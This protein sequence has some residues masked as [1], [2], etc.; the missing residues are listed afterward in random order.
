MR[1]VRSL[2][3][4]VVVALGLGAYIYFVES[5]REPSDVETKS[6]AFTVEADAID[7]LDITVPADSSSTTLK[8]TNGTWAVT[9]PVSAPADDVAVGGITSALASL[10]I[11]RE[12]DENPG[13]LAQFGLEV[14]AVTVAF[15]A[16]GTTHRLDI[17]NKTPTNSN[18]YARVDGQ[19]KLLLIPAMHDTTFRRSTFE[20]RDKRVVTLERHAVDA[21]TLAQ[22]G[23]PPISLALQNGNWRFTAPLAAPAEFSPVDGLVGRALDARMTSIV[24]EGTEPTA[25][26]LRSYGLDA[27]QLTVTLGAGSARATLAI[28]GKK[29]ETSLYARDLSRPIVFTVEPTLLTD[30]TKTPDDLRVRTIFTFQPYTANGLDLTHGATVVSFGKAAPSGDAT[31]ADVW[32]QLTP[33]AKDV[34]QTALADLLNTLSSLRADRFIDRA[35]ASGDDMVVVARSGDANAP[36]EERVTLRKSGDTTY[37]LRANEPGAAVIPT[38]DFDKAVTQLQALT[39]AK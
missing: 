7:E 28:G 3:F 16:G 6:K 39:S 20:L 36:V 12:L 18:L 21:V 1:G 29:D 4:L 37:A 25:A 27:P 35:P 34:N 26:Q 19:S 11:D 14:P 33:E 38:A 8:K 22:R 2:L 23:T 30:L 31:A 15:K 13:S 10:D 32:K 17:G 24:S 9:A 5:K